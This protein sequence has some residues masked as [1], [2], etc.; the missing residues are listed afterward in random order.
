[1]GSTKLFNPH[2]SVD[3]VLMSIIDDRL[4][5]LLVER[6]DKNGVTLGLKLP[7]GLIYQ[8]EDLDEA[9]NRVLNE[10]TGMKRIQ[11]KQFRCFGSPERTQNKEDVMWLESASNQKIMDSYEGVIRI[12]TVAYLALCKPDRKA[13]DSEFEFRHWVAI[14]EMPRMPFDHN[15]IVKAAVLEI[16]NWIDHEPSIIFNYLRKKFTA[17]ELRRTYEIL[18]GKKLDVRNFDKRMKSWEY[19]IPT[20]DLKVGQAYRSPRYYRFDKVMY[21]KQRAKLSKN[22]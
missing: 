17:S 1:M 2:V 18:Y 13:A 14:D 15:T 9:A 11:L 19:V 12:V 8:T 22:N 5:V 21:N 3:C 10:A 6:F 20:D 16:R 4:S 7:G